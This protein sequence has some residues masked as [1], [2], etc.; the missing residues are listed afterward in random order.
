MSDTLDRLTR[1]AQRVLRRRK[2]YAIPCHE[3]KSQVRSDGSPTKLAQP[4]TP[5]VGIATNPVFV[6]YA[7]STQPFANPG[8][9]H[10]VRRDEADA[11]NVFNTDSYDEINL[12]SLPQ[13]PQIVSTAGVAKAE[14]E[15]VLRT[16]VF[17]TGPKRRKDHHS[18]RVPR[19]I[20]KAKLKRIR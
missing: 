12:P 5:F 11:P 8:G 20:R 18:P 9:F 6:T 17:L 14:L 10:A 4:L 2:I 7:M 1:A 16:H 3:W 15:S 13:W 19:D